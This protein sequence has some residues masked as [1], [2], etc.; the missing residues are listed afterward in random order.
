L[1]G[2]PENSPASEGSLLIS[3][4]LQASFGVPEDRQSPR[5]LTTTVNLRPLRNLRSF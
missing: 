5:L 2:I 1:N 3:S 4:S